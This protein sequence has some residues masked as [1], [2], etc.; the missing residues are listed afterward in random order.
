MVVNRGNP[1]WNNTSQDLINKSQV[2]VHQVKADRKEDSYPKIIFDA[3]M[4]LKTP[5][6]RTISDFC[7]FKRKEVLTIFN[8]LIRPLQAEG[9]I[10]TLNYVFISSDST[11]DAS[12]ILLDSFS[13]KLVNPD[14]FDQSKPKFPKNETTA[15]FKQTYSDYIAKGGIP[16]EC[17]YTYLKN[18][19]AELTEDE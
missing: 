6:V 16:E 13:H 18:V 15:M 8:G 14:K 17:G 9:L 4:K 3:L 12:A 5:K 7:C 11:Y 2:V 1:Y 19:K 10:D